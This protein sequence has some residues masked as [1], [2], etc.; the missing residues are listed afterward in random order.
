MEYFKKSYHACGYMSVLHCGS[1][2]G[3]LL[4]LPF[5]LR[6]HKNDKKKIA[7]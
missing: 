5:Q 6:L 3:G 2:S 1:L 4:P 7:K